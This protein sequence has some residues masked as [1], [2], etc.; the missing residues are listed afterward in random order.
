MKISI[1][2]VS[3][4]SEKTI[5]QTIRSVLSQEN[6]DIEYIIIDGGSTDGTLDIIKKYQDNITSWTSEK[7]E[8]IYDAMNKGIK[9]TTGDV[10]GILNSDDFYPSSNV[11]EKIMKCFRDNPTV[12]ACYGDLIFVEKNNIRNITRY[13]KTGDYNRKNL[14]YGWMMPHPT[15]FVRASV[16]EKVG[17]FRTD[18]FIAADYELMIR[19]L[20]VHN[21]KIIYI[22]EVL[23]CMRTGGY[24]GKNIFRRFLSWKEQY[25]AWFVNDIT[26]PFFLVLSRFLKRIPE[27]FNKPSTKN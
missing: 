3:F 12:N 19:A 14:K 15:F 11:L 24:S 26:P 27:F 4:N 7:D 10:V 17:L 2:T 5:E 9:R 23:A 20:K 1:I 22:P 13:W 16:Y 18:F 6:V 21:I 25:R 8:G